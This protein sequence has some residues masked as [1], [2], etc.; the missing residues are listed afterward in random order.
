MTGGPLGRLFEHD[1]ASR[2]YPAAMSAA[3]LKKV[4]WPR[5]GPAFDQGDIGSC[6]GNAIAG[7]LNTAPYHRPRARRLTEDKAVEIYALATVLDGFDGTYPPDDTGSSG[8]AACKAAKQLGLISE[9]RHAFGLDHALAALQLGPVITGID[10]FNGFDSPG[11]RGL[12]QIAGTVRGGHEIE[13]FG[14]D[15]LNDLV[16]FWQSWG[17]RWGWYGRGCMTT[18][19]WRE[20][21]ARDGDVTVPTPKARPG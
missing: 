12:I 6:T 14:H 5:S 3:P 13:I 11:K 20:L 16:W 8:L 4:M 15:P 9:Y 17:P 18:G 1:P 21:L 7:V 19:T 2:R 10:W